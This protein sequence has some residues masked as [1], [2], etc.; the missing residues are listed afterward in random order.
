M[1]HLTSLQ[2][3]VSPDI[4]QPNYKGVFLPRLECLSLDLS[5]TEETYTFLHRHRKTIRDLWTAYAPHPHPCHQIGP[6]PQL[7]SCYASMHIALI[8]LPGSRVND[9]GISFAEGFYP[10]M[11]QPTTMQLRCLDDFQIKTASVDVWEGTVEAAIMCLDH[12]RN[13]E[14]ICIGLDCEADDMVPVCS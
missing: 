1:T 12:M 4:S 11:M 7:S 13:V 9:I 14:E 10:T 8:I 5:F 3:R 6:F 2:I